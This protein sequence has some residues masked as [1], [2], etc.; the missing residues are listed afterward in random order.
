MNNKPLVTIGVVSYNSAKTIVETLDSAYKQT[1]PNI[2][3][4]V[5]DDGS[6]D[7]TI[8]CVSS[9]IHSHASR[10]NHCILLTTETNSGTPANCNRVVKHTHGDYIKLIAADDMLMPNC[11]N[12]FVEFFSSN[13]DI[14]I[15]YSNYYCFHFTS[16]GNYEI[17]QE[18]FSPDIISGFNVIPNKQLYFYIENSFNISP[19]VFMTKLLIDKMGGYNEKYKV[20]EDTP[21]FTKVLMNNVKIY[22]LSSSTVMY[23]LGAD[24][25]TTSKPHTFFNTQFYDCRLLFRKD[26]IYELYKWYNLPFW[27]KEYSFRFQYWFTVKILHNKRNKATNVIYHIVKCCNPYYVI[28]YLCNKKW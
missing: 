23:R 13:P 24:S 2:E 21:F 26:I 3:L 28:N 15:A 19:S 12:D 14:Q 10:F 25:I 7:N 17:V 5:S 22:H 8:E 20:F 4:I 1:Y 27:I 11:I 6:S 18:R 16:N 9:W